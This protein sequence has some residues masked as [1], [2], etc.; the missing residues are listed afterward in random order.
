MRESIRGA[1]SPLHA[2]PRDLEEV[3]DMIETKE[4]RRFLPLRTAR[5]VLVAA[6]LAAALTLTA[7]AADYVVNGR[8]VFFF[9]TLD[10]LARQ[11]AADRADDPEAAVYAGV[12]GTAD[13]AAADM[14][15]SAEYVARAMDRGL[16]DGET[17]VSR[18]SGSYAADGW[19]RRVVRTCTDDYYGAV[20]TEYRTAD[21]YAGHVAVEGVLDWDLS[22]L[23]GQL[24][25][26]QDGQICVTACSQT[27]GDVVFAKVHVGYQT[28]G[29]QPVFVN[30]SYD[31]QT[32]YGQEPEYVLSDAYDWCGLY[33]TA[34]GVQVLLET[35]DGQVWAS[36]AQGHMRVDLYA[37]GGCTLD[38]MK[39]ILDGLGLAGVLA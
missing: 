2:S 37:L 39:A 12:P 14:E 32:D 17:E 33:T 28:A 35:Y 27:S 5:A 7:F 34:D 6:A 36:A 31:A 19:T 22:A 15:T 1:F 38:E 23:A 26:A 9:D 13:A 4:K 21:Q 25:P 24:T 29:G 10:A 8:Q 16:L 18:E 20:I 30:C 3:L 11:Q